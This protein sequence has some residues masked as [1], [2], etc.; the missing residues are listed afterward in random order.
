[1]RTQK[2]M[3]TRGR[4]AEIMVTEKTVIH[5][6][7]TDLKLLAIAGVASTL[8]NVDNVSQMVDDIEQYKEKMS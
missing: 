6:T 8:A 3:D 5:G 7:N 4:P 1:M 2:N